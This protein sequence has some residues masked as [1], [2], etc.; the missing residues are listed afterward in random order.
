[1]R[2]LESCN[3]SSISNG[4]FS[5]EIESGGIRTTLDTSL[6]VQKPLR[7]N[8]GWRLN[9][10]RIEGVCKYKMKNESNVNYF[11]SDLDLHLVLVYS[12]FT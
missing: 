8:K 9:N 7:Q 12:K 1:M 11:R 2:S 3:S 10:V 5:L 4:A 6:G